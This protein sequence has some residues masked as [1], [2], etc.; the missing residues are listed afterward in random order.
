MNQIVQINYY[1]PTKM[2][3]VQYASKEHCHNSD[4]WSENKN[5]S[6]TKNDPIL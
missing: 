4:G 5:L 6:K 3:R 2:Y 1:T